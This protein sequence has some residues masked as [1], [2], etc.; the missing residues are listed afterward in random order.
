MAVAI[1]SYILVGLVFIIIAIPLVQNKIKPNNFYGFRTR[2]TLSDPKIWYPANAYAARW[3]IAMGVICVLSAVGFVLVPFIVLE[4][5]L[6]IT[7]GLI[8][9]GFILSGFFCFRYISRL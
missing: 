7:I 4:S 3:L 9:G 5:Y 1:I 2:K 6:G 8:I